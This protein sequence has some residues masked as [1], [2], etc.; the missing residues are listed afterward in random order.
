MLIYDLKRINDFSE[1]LDYARKGDNLRIKNVFEHYESA[2]RY[3]FREQG[4]DGKCHLDVEY[5]ANERI[6]VSIT[7]VILDDW[8]EWYN[9]GF[10]LYVVVF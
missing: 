3:T 5:N 4:D 2:L 9:G 6:S 8:F 1:F 10:E 7:N